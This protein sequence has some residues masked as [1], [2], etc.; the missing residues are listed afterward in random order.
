MPTRRAGGLTKVR[1]RLPS[2]QESQVE[3]LG[4]GAEAAPAVVELLVR[5]G[6]RRAMILTLSSTTPGD[7]IGRRSKR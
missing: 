4:T 7:P 3:I 1:L 2:E 6:A 5:I